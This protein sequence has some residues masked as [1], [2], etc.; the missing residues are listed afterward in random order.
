LHSDPA[1]VALAPAVQ[2]ANP[3]G[4]GGPSL[5]GIVLPAA[6]GS[7][8]L[9]IVLALSGVL[10]FG[11]LTADGLTPAQLRRRWRSSWIHRHPWNWHG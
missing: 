2:A 9:L 6:A 1:S 3:S 5:P 7:L 4:G 8:L 10:G 11:L